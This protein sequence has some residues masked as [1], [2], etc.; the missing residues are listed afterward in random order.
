MGQKGGGVMN[1][2]Q[3]FLGDNLDLILEQSTVAIIGL[4]GGGSQVVQQ[5][6]HIGFKRYI[7]CDFD[8]LEDTNLNRT[9]G[10][11]MED[12]EQA[13]RKLD[14]A[15]RLIKKI[16]PDAHITDLVDKFQLFPQEL[17]NA[18]I[19]FG[20]LDGLQNRNELEKFAR[21]KEIP[22]IDIGM[23]VTNSAGTYV[24][25]GQVIASLPNKPCMWCM[26]FLNSEKLGQE[27]AKYGESGHRP[28]VIWSNGV[29]SSTA[30]HV[31]MN[32][33]TNWTGRLDHQTLYY[34]YDGNK[35]IVRPHIHYEKH[36]RDT[37]PHHIYS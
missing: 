21:R 26:E 16:V 18:T 7:L 15:V 9:V 13:S 2:R 32:L 35:G 14:I 17:S 1:N 29:L 30:V 31:G 23:D 33:L 22:Y 37:C 20:C 25:R 34:E 8:R 12:V 24:M 36:L 5:L 10:A 28:Q 19:I 3:S 4:G 11:T 6:A 27:A